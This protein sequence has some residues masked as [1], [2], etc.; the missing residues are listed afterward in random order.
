VH[1]HFGSPK[2]LQQFVNKAHEKG[3]AVIIDWVPNHMGPGNILE[4]FDNLD[5]EGF[6]GNYFYPD[7][8]RNTDYG[9]RLDYS[10]PKVRKM[11]KDSLTMWI[12]DYH[13]D[14]IRVDSTIT[15]RKSD[16]MDLLEA[17]TF[18]QECNDFVIKNYPNVLMIAEDLQNHSHINWVA[19]YHSQW[20][21]DF[22]SVMYNTVRTLNDSD[23]NTEAVWHAISKKFTANIHS[24]VIYTE[25]H[26]TIPSDRQSRLPVA[27][28]PNSPNDFYAVQRSILAVALLL[29]SPGIPMLLQGQEILELSCP[30]WPK[31]PTIDWSKQQTN[32][33]VFFGLPKSHPPP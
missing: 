4:N 14:G 29:T 15:M 12:R 11:L 25:N 30:V 33:H 20:D 24:R 17:W 16:N 21:P 18:M 28:S 1:S 10:N 9:P 31:P 23:R 26:D 3:I 22:F 6:L 32:R 13:M 27:I 5:R 19:G 7:N 8:R 2:D